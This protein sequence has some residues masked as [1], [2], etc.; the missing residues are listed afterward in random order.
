M[1]N[2]KP[3]PGRILLIGIGNCGRGD[4]G[5]GWRFADYICESGYDFFD[6]EYR[7]QLQVE[8]A[9]L[10]RNYDM[11]IFVD[12]TIAKNGSGFEMKL[13]KPATGFYFSSHKQSPETILFLS[14]HLFDKSPEAY[15]LSI[16]GCEW[17]LKT[18][19]HENAEKNLNAAI[20]H[21]END[22]LP[23]ILPHRRHRK[24]AG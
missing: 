11:V 21:F 16:S 13:C 17:D 1:K 7:Y 5:L 9:E 19:L 10:V 6:V 15:V 2:V 23:S 14:A 20:D 12:A 4:D 3:D 22:F 18:L 24:P 8:D